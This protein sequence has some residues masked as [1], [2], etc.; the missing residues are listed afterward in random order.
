MKSKWI[1]LILLLTVIFSC[2]NENQI[3]FES[4]GI[5]TQLDN[6]LCQCCRGY[7]I[8]IEDDKNNYR[9]GSLPD[10]I[11][12]NQ[13]ELPINVKVNW[14]LQSTCEAIGISY[15]NIEAIEIR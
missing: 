3:E 10:G 7:I 14:D 9:I 12:I 6:R 5:I 1:I 13:D 4:N 2:K 8:Q 15:I 11:Q